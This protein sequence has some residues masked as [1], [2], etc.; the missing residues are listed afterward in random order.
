MSQI[1][2][3][4][5]FLKTAIVVCDRVYASHSLWLGRQNQAMEYVVHYEQR[6]FEWRVQ[7]GWC[8]LRNRPKLWLEMNQTKVS[9]KNLLMKSSGNNSIF[10][11]VMWNMQASKNLGKKAILKI[12]EL[13]SLGGVKTHLGKL[14]LKCCTFRREKYFNSYYVIAHDP[15]RI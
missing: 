10:Y 12:W 7:S 13:I 3:R 4:Q 15:I 6:L 14:A 8:C 9:P 11:L 1:L 5:K 2:F